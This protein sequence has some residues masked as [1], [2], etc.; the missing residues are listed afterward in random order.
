MSIAVTLPFAL[1]LFGAGLSLALHRWLQ[2]QRLLT[3]AVLGACTVNAVVVVVH[4]YS[5]GPVAVHLGAWPAQVG[6]V[7]AADMLSALLLLVSLVTTLAV[8]VFAIGQAGT[9]E[10]W[11]IFHPTLLVLTAGVSAS[12]LT[13]DLFHLF[14]AFEVMLSASYVLLTLGGRRPQ[15]RSGITYTVINFAASTVLLAA[16]GLVYAAT[17][18]V[19]MGELALRMP[20]LDPAL[21][22]ALTL[23]LLVVFGT[24]AAIFPLFFWL[25]DSYPTASSAVTAVFAGLLT[26]V[27]IY[28]I[29]RTQTLF[30]PGS[31]PSPLL[32]TL[33][34]PTM[35]VGILGAVAQDDMKRILSF[36][37]VSQIGYMLFGLALWSQAGLAAAIFFTFHQIPVKTALFLSAGLVEDGA[38]SSSISHLGGMVRRMPWAAACFGLAAWS[39]AGLPP[40]SG[41]LGKLGLVQA[42]FGAEQWLVTGISLAVSLLTTFSMTKIW[43]GVFWGPDEAPR[44]G[45]MVAAGAASATVPLRV[46]PLMTG[47][48]AGLVLFTLLVAVFGGPLLDACQMAATSLLD[49]AAY[50]DAVLAR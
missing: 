8:A 42:G 10:R 13:A 23:L 6:I 35:V 31:G 25:P 41:F 40:T 20:D 15:V 26:K 44:L 4:V 37:I 36:H 19:N 43:G 24:K 28:T 14:V 12:F 17:G 2:V 16:V 22:D 39:L 49:P 1:C 33:A 45:G 34:A 11:S 5:N 29:I 21:R 9:D 3:L 27:G 38:G 48:T 18:T 50:L 46:S 30:D 32:L 47:A 7:Y